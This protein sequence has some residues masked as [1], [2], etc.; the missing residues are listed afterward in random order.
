MEAH[1]HKTHK[2]KTHQQIAD[3]RNIVLPEINP[4]KKPKSD[5]T[6][7]FMDSSGYVNSLALQS[8]RAKKID[9]MRS[10]AVSNQPAKPKPRYSN[11]ASTRGRLRAM[12]KLASDPTK[13]NNI[14]EPITCPS[15]HSG[16]H[17]SP[18]G[19]RRRPSRTMNTGDF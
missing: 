11:I 8:E 7:A 9:Q 10:S 3:Q 5:L 1:K 15:P 16:P 4:K 19:R 13:A 12:E 2:Y 17:S 6:L 14:P 18:Q